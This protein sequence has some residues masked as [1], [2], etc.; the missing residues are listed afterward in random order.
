VSR[1][2]KV[3]EE[4]LGIQLFERYNREIKL[5]LAGQEYLTALTDSFAR[6]DAATRRLAESRRERP[7][8]LW[9]SMTF[10][11][12]WLLPRMLSFHAAHP[13]RDLNLTTT[14]K[15]I[16]FESDNWDVAI[17]PGDGKWRNLHS[18]YLLGVDLAPACSPSLLISGPPLHTVD[19][20][21][22][23]TLLHT[24][25]RPLHWSK[26]L[27]LA[28]AAGVDPTRGIHFQ[29]SS[30]AYK[31][32]I[33]GMGVACGHLALIEDDLAAGRLVT[34]FNTVLHDDEAYYLIYPERS[35]NNENLK[36]LREWL[37][38]ETCICG[39]SLSEDRKMAGVI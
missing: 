9:C 4:F 11:L 13:Q 6:L 3:L 36:Y 19:D 16:D 39:P 25:A 24:S 23:H 1:Q 14:S 27:A 29:S 8:N 38:A 32:A 37:L 7:L 31:A 30:L 17:R 33:E 21:A 26:W 28:G 35:A 2:I 15:P 34:P 5:T 10:T 18:H 22:K 12:R 20:L